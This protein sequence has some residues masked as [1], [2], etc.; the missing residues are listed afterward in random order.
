MN[1]QFVAGPILQETIYGGL[2][3]DQLVTGGSFQESSQACIVDLIPP[4]FSGIADL[5]RGAVGQLRASW[6]AGSDVSLPLRYEIYCQ[7]STPVNLFNSS[8]LVG[9][10]AQLNFNIFALANG[11]LL[12]DNVIYHVGVRAVDAVGNRDNNIVSISQT[13]PGISGV[14][15]GQISGVFAINEFNQLV[16][17]F[18][19]NDA[20]GI[21]DNTARL[22]A[23]SYEIFDEQGNLVPGMSEINILADAR[24]FFEITPVASTLDLTNSYYTVLVTIPI[25]GVSITYN[26]P[27]T[28]NEAASQFEPR[29]VFSIN[30]ANELEGSIWITKNSQKLASNLGAASYSIRNKSGVLIGISESG[31]SADANGIYHITPVAASSIVD[32]NHYTVDIS[33]T[34]EGVVRSGVVAILVGE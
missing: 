26:L 6:L 28:Y 30:A 34:A 27:I 2:E 25:D 1:N 29:A 15:G 7:P 12:Q 8:N 10:T 16:A 20:D 23:A 17:T 9:I 19:A 13:T 3:V 31:I 18:W 21:I 11:T 4:T 5:V 14:V 32:L 24:G 33:I 22:G